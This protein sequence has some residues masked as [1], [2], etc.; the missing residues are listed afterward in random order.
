MEVISKMKQWIR[1]QLET[2]QLLKDLK[3]MKQQ[4]KK[5]GWDIY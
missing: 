3:L 2:L 5:R 1:K 4:L